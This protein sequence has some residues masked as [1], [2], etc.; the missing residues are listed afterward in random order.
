MFPV[1]LE[2]EKLVVLPMRLETDATVVE[3]NFLE[4]VVIAG[5]LGLAI[6]VQNNVG[7][8]NDIHPTII[9][10]PTTVSIAVNPLG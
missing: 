8:A 6:G 3:T 2:S 4:Q 5:F 9:V 7:V 10:G 1:E